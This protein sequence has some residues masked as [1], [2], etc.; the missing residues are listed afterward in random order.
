MAITPGSDVNQEV[1][2]LPRGSV[3]ER[4]GALSRQ[5]FN[6]FQGKDRMLG[7]IISGVNRNRQNIVQL[8]V[9][10]QAADGTLSSAYIAAD[11]VVFANSELSNATLST[12][13]T[14]AFQAADSTLQG[15]INTNV[16]NITTL[17]ST[18]ATN[19]SAIATL[20]TN[21]TAETTARQSAD[22]ALQNDINTRATVTQLQTAE[23]NLTGAIATVQTNLTAET[24][25][26]TNA[27]TA[28]QSDINTRATVTQLQTAES[29]LN[30]AIATSATNLTAAYQAAD[31]T[32]QSDINT[33]AT[34]AAL[35]AES[36]ARA[37]GDSANAT[38]ITNL[39]ASVTKLAVASGPINVADTEYFTNLRGGD[40]LTIAD[41]TLYTPSVVNDSSIGRAL[42]NVWTAAGNN[43]LTKQLFEIDT[44]K[45]YRVRIVY[46]VSTLPTD[47]TANLSALV[48]GVIP[49]S[50]FSNPAIVFVPSFNVSVTTRQVAEFTISSAAS[51]AT[52]ATY[53][54][55]GST[56]FR[57]GLRQGSNETT[58]V[59][60][61]TIEVFDATAETSNAANITTLQSTTATNTSAISTLTTN[62]SAEV[63]NR[64]NAD[65]ALQT[66]INTR[67]TSAAL[68]AESTARASGDSANATSITN[69][70]ATVTANRDD[71]DAV[72]WSDVARIWDWSDGTVQ[73]WSAVNS[74]IAAAADGGLVVTQSGGNTD[75]HIRTPSGL[76]IT[77][78]RYY[79]VV[80]DVECVTLGS[81]GAHDLTL[82]Y[83]TGGHGESSSFNDFPR[84][85]AAFTAAGERRLCVYDMDTQATGA[86][87]WI[88]STITRVRLDLPQRSGSVWKVH[89]FKVVGIN[90]QTS[91]ANVTNIAEA[92]AT[93]DAAKARLVW[94]VNT[95]T[96]AATIEQTAATGFSDGTWNGSAIKL[97]ADLLELLAKDIN[98][99]TNT[100]FED[101]YGTIST[102]K[103]NKRL[104]MLGPFPA[105]DD[106]VL[107]FGPTSV[108]LNSESK[109]NGH[110]ALGTD[111]KIYLGN[112]E[113]TISGTLDFTYT[114]GFVKTLIGNGTNTTNQVSFTGTGGSGS[115]YTFAHELILTSTTGPTPTISSSSG[116]PITVSATGVVGDTV[117]FF[118]QTT[119]TDSAGNKATKSRGGLLNWDI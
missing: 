59:D 96:N 51:S 63:T 55:S 12:N 90:T 5:F 60:I 10:Y 98:F 52:N 34:S 78:S 69:L 16:A 9:D 91:I 39:S 54:G 117:I 1:E 103:N 38:S 89:S 17:Q 43:T 21:L 37:S 23:T 107:W 64:T 76:T 19:S 97:S 116:S 46:R 20:Q 84:N 80:A 29:T 53:P 66:D 118:V 86:P 109:T 92:Y 112:A 15:Q 11:A 42:R 7:E 73:G 77:G 49:S 36:S 58:T 72:T 101:T 41:A 61:A 32:L 95:S 113:L 30:A 68:T 119:V 28:L 104:R 70:T 48:A 115:G 105:S 114:N 13:L 110:F 111:G 56:H 44:S 22:T 94:T 33:R 31:A 40:P 108:S 83:S 99:G 75:I 62:L 26:R 87:D 102:T 67:A 74:T 6:W 106:I 65:T 35:S 2:P 8:E 93:N 45:T 18:T 81:A 47:G 79:K 71:Q 27:D 24:T 100:T 14:A 25:A 50:S 4:N 82:F 85:N 57:V 88:T 3:V